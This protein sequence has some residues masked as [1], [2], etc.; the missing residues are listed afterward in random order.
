MVFGIRPS[1]GFEQS[2]LTVILEKLIV[3]SV[4]DILDLLRNP[5]VQ[6]LFHKSPTAD[7]GEGQVNSVHTF[8]LITH[9]TIIVSSAP[10]S[11]NYS[12]PFTSFDTYNHYIEKKLQL[13]F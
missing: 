2:Q 7:Y 1:T 11:L 3:A 9:S 8:V 4:P 12:R 10:S 13:S 5:Q 6:Y